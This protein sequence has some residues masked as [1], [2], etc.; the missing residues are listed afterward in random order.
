MWPRTTQLNSLIDANL[1]KKPS[2]TV[3]FAEVMQYVPEF[4]GRVRGFRGML[5]PFYFR[6]EAA[7]EFCSS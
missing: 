7:A 1:L 3:M 5:R 2:N 4:G 6:P